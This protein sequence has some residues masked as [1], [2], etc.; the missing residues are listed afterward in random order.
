MPFFRGQRGPIYQEC[1]T[2]PST[3]DRPPSVNA[4]DLL[5]DLLRQLW[6]PLIVPM[7]EPAFTTR[8]GTV[9]KL[10]D[11]KPLIHTHPLGKRICIL[12]VDTRDHT[13]EGA[14]F[15]STLPKFSNIKLQTAG[16]LSHYLYATIHGYTYKFL[17]V[18]SYKDRAPHWTKIIFTQ[19]LLK[20][21]DIVVM[22]DY[23]TMFPSPQLPLEW[24]LNYWQID[25]DVIVAMA[26]DP[27]A[28]HNLDRKGNINL[29][30]G[31]II[32]QSMG[33]PE[34]TQEFFKDWAECPEE[35]RHKGCAK[36]KD[37]VFHEQSGFSSFVR[38]DFF[39]EK[40][41]VET[42]EGAKYIRKLPCSEANGIPDVK[43]TGCVGHLVRHFW[44]NKFATP[45]E[46]SESILENLVPLLTKAAFGDPDIV[47]DYRGMVLEGDRIL[48]VKGL[49]KP[50][51]NHA[52]E[53]AD[54]KSGV[55][56]SN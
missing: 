51:A 41:S 30:T 29:N 50:G 7:T 48:D 13:E 6:A 38:Y 17:R 3:S 56:R 52:N 37:V 10:P 49:G 28:A 55:A 5:P 53:G 54:L 21:F 32:A 20:E 46:L 40:L 24:M 42:A 8:D 34:K 31:F 4:F 36:Y 9:K 14:V 11:N 1:V 23:D 16:Y 2:P 43:D 22:L 27:D 12:D 39:K 44:G 19:E 33:S 47:R 15:A 45:R 25:R 18:P 35:K 26:E